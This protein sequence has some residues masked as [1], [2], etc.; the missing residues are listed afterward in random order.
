MERVQTRS[1]TRAAAPAAAAASSER[2]LPPSEQGEETASIGSIPS[3]STPSKTLR[4]YQSKI[5]DTCE[6]QNT[7]VLL[8][9]GAGKTAIAAEVIK[10]I[11]RPALFLVP[12][13]NLVKQQARAL[14][15]WT[16]LWVVELRGGDNVPAHFEV[17]VATAG[18]FMAAQKDKKICDLQW[19][20]FRVVVF[21]EV[22]WKTVK[23]F[24]LLCV[25]EYR[26]SPRPTPEY[27]VAVS[28]LQMEYRVCLVLLVSG[29][30]FEIAEEE[31]PKYLIPLLV[32]YPQNLGV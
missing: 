21:D 30:T 24:S 16:G 17:L 18:A 11:P 13:C 20:R 6:R 3:V 7:L 5:A 31:T 8:P 9:T 2:T 19:R 12:T 28:N 15:S 14:R 1:M 26:A 25:Q 27:R 4:R 10:R 22:R 32:V 29:C 23:G